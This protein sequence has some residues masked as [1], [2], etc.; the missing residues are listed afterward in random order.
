MKFLI[1]DDDTCGFTKVDE[2]ERCYHNIWGNIPV[3]L[4][5]TPFRIPGFSDHLPEEY[6]GKTSPVALE[7]NKSLVNFIKDG[8]IKGTL[9]IAL[10]G[11]HHFADISEKTPEQ[12]EKIDPRIIGR[13]YLLGKDLKMKTSQ[14]KVY[15][16]KLFNCKV[17]TFV[18]PGNSISK[19]GIKA[20]AQNKLN[21]VTS[22]SLWRP[23]TR[24]FHVINYIN[25]VRRFGWRV[26]TGN[27][28]YPFVIDCK[29][30]K[31][32]ASNMLYPETKLDKLIED[33]D[34]CYSVNGV[35]ILS[36]HY[37]EFQNVIN[38]GETVE[39]A[40]HEIIN[41]VSGKTNIDYITYRDLW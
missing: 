36:V 11:Y 15:L 29:T 3:C 10:H 40:L 25:A 20:I 5:V 28:R 8:L 18:P 26:K 17:N 14:G 35:F 33:L 19:E 32:I 9:D 21:L 12:L 24:P 23:G 7:E 41:Y 4:S 39:E 13:E 1:R 6:H 22:P 16:E 37:H 30:H 34:F 27:K 38:S 2:I 31:E